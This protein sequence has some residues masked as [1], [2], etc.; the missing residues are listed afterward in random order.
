MSQ[1]ELDEALAKIRSEQVND[2]V[3]KKAAGRVFRSL[4]DSAFIA[5]EPSGKIRGC[6]DVR[7]LIPAY[8]NRTLSGPRSLLL[9]DHV[10]TCVD[11]R[12]A[13]HDARSGSAPVR[14]IPINRPRRKHV[15]MLVWAAAAALVI[16]IG[17]GLTGRLPGQNTLRAT[18][19]S[20]QGTV[21]KVT[22][23]TVSLVEAGQILKNTDELRTAKGSHAILRLAGGTI[24]EIAERSD[25]SLSGG[26][27]GTSLNLERGQMIVDTHNQLQKTLTVRS[28]EMNTPVREGVVAFDHG[29]KESVVAVARGSFQVTTAAATKQLKAGELYGGELH[30]VNLPITSEFAWSEKSASYID[31]LK[32]QLSGL[33]KD[34]QSIPSPGLRYSSNLPQYLP[35]DTFI[36]AA[37]PNLGG[38]ITEAKKLFDSR[39]AESEALREWWQ[40]KAIA[41]NGE[42]DHIV[43]QIAAIHSYLGDEVVIAVGGDVAGSQAGP[44]FMAEIKQPGL[45]GYL[46]SNLPA[47]AEV[48]IVTAG[49]PVN[50]GNKLLVQMDNNILVATSS[51]TQL[52]R[53][54]AIVQKLAPGGFNST[55]FFARI[56]KVYQNGAGF[57]LAANLE[58]ITAKSVNQSKAAVPA[59][60][61]NVQY[62]VLERKGESEMRASLSF[63]GARNGVASWLGTPGP[64]G[65]LDFVSPDANFAASIVMKNPRVMMQEL[66]G[67]AG[68]SDPNFTQQLSAFEAHAG[69]NLLD[70]V[71]A[72]LGSDV[73]IAMEGITPILALE[74][75]DP[76]KLQQTLGV[77]TDSFNR[78]APATAGRL[79]LASSQVN[80]RTFFS[81]SNSKSPALAAYYTFVDGYLLASS[82]QANVLTAIQ[83]KQTGHTLASSDNFIAKLPVDGY[84]NFSAM[85][86]SNL[87]PLGDLA[88]QLPSSQKQQALSGL[89]ANSGPGLV[90]V[91]GE[92]DRIVAAARGSFLG[93]DLGTLV[94]IE[95]GKPLKTMIANAPIGTPKGVVN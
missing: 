68:G 38:T 59:G 91:Y 62:L 54:E 27:S 66:L 15:P 56:E 72:P 94:G 84:P 22:D 7:A 70:D 13:L 39:L 29:T 36:Y 92:T 71:A 45:A 19:A 3:V 35:A 69:V 32:Q 40:Q 90:C 12:H 83:N 52:Q 28:G 50:G 20:V 53:V 1:H 18:V 67:M 75:Y 21:Y 49:S 63:D 11:C 37:I 33:Q 95:E 43:D 6:A 80:G 74:V 82:S 41:K 76:G 55:P 78:Q 57:F 93:F 16:G 4:F 2:E 88:K 9:E 85:V 8:L 48:Q 5:T 77:L 30:T 73:T 17:L 44:V 81:I 65:S 14:P 60:L 24:V 51:A 86:Y 42:F 46:Q 64:A 47:N 23:L 79:T 31:L 10:L 61:A 89:I 26:W 58:Q 25:V 34:I 87:S